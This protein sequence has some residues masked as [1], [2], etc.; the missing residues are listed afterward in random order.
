MV[1]FLLA[2]SIFGRKN[3]TNNTEM[4]YGFKL[5]LLPEDEI[6]LYIITELISSRLNHYKTAK[7][8]HVHVA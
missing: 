1:K 4:L 3:P 8:K 5:L 2:I 7:I 6:R